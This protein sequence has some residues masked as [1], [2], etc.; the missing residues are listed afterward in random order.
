MDASLRPLL[1][2]LSTPEFDEYGGLTLRA[3][4]W[5]DGGLTLD[6][7]VRQQ[8]HADEPWRL[9]C[10]NVRRSRIVNDQ[11]IDPLRIETRHPLLLPHTEELLE[12]YFSSRPPD[13]D[14]AVG[15]LVEAHRAVVG[16]WFDCLHFFNLG[17]DRSLRTMLDGGFGKLAEGPRPLIEGYAEVL[18]RAGVAV[19]SPPPRSPA[20]WNGERWVEESGPLFALILGES[21]IVSPSVTAERDING[22][23]VL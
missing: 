17:P 21:Y 4:T 23:G 1:D 14:A 19:S 3:V 12:L 2:T 18:R 9:L 7:I 6:L 13:P 16:P 15:Q 20:W 22:S 8:D 5:A 11:G 10:R